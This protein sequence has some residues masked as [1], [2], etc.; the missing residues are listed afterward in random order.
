MMAQ[1][2]YAKWSMNGNE[3]ECV[4]NCVDNC[5]FFWVSDKWMMISLCS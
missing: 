2:R 1:Y 5:H 3:I 4:S